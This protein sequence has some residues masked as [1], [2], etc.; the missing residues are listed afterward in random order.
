MPSRL[1]PPF[2]WA[3]G[4]PVRPALANGLAVVDELMFQTVL[5]PTE[6]FSSLFSHFKGLLLSCA[7]GICQLQ[8]EVIALNRSRSLR[9]FG[10]GDAIGGVAAVAWES[11]GVFSL[12]FSA[13]KSALSIIP[14]RPISSRASSIQVL[15]RLQRGPKPGFRTLGGALGEMKGYD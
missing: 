3:T 6:R 14:F 9:A 13:P 11:R 2:R 10:R 12:T 1:L 4:V 8:T 7:R 15:T 5:R